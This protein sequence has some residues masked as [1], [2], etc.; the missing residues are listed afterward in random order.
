MSEFDNKG[1]IFT[2]VLK[3]REKRSTFDLSHDVEDWENYNQLFDGTQTDEINQQLSNIRPRAWEH[4]YFTSALPFAQKG[5]EVTIPIDLGTDVSNNINNVSKMY[6]YIDYNKEAAPEQPLKAGTTTGFGGNYIQATW[7]DQT[8]GAIIDNSGSLFNQ[9]TI[10]DLRAAIKLQEWLETN[11]RGGSRYFVS[12][13]AHFGVKSPDSRLQRPEFIGSSRSNMVISEVL[14]TSS[15]Q[16]ETDT[17]QGNMSGHGQAVDSSKTFTHYSQEHGH[18]IGIMSVMP[19]TAYQ[20]GIPR[21]FSKTIDKLQY[22]YPEFAHLG[23]QEI[24]NLE[25]YAGGDVDTAIGTFGYTPRYSEYKFLNSRV[26]GDFRDT[27]AFWHM[28]R[29]FDNAPM[30]NDF[31]ISSNPTKRIFAVQD[32]PQDSESPSTEGIRDYHSLYAHVFHDV[33]ANRLMPKYGTPTL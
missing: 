25:I 6:S 12:I 23:E 32:L 14:Q 31:F 26:A 8:T 4:D 21:M 18:I 13:Y 5:E 22:Y 24:L 29:I 27:L 15:P 30:L 2:S 20:Q 19:K 9:S 33:K 16:A 10:N 1:G 17:P 7:T 28:G 3:K 11:A